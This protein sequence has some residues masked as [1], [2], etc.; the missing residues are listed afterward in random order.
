MKRMSLVYT[1]TY[2]TLSLILIHR[3]YHVILINRVYRVVI[4][5]THDKRMLIKVS[6]MSN[7]NDRVEIVGILNRP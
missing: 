4:S 2:N 5:Y 3:V 1:C 7:D 6:D